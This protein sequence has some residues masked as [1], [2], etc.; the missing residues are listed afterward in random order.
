M[1]HVTVSH[2]S[3][4]KYI[5]YRALF[6]LESDFHVPPSRTA[7]CS[8]GPG[9]AGGAGDAGDSVDT[10]AQLPHAARDAHPHPGPHRG[11]QGQA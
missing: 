3:C 9:E 10:A 4:G 8:A 6:C 2:D 7:E 1:Q 11:L 5:L